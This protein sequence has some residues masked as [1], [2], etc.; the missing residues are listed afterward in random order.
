MSRSAATVT[1]F[2][3]LS[4]SSTLSAEKPLFPK[5]ISLEGHEFE[6]LGEYRYVYR[7]FFPLYEVA[8][9]TEARACAE[10]VLTA[11][12][13]FRLQFRYLREIEKSIILK[14]AGRML[15]KNLSGKEQKAIA[16]RVATINRAYTSVGK[17]DRS[18]LTFIPEEG[19]TLRING[20]TK[21]TVAGNDFARLYLQIWLGPEPISR[22][23]RDHLLGDI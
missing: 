3:L 15:E 21:V 11:K 6:R 1:T 18:S 8:L 19:T 13:P 4:L 7:I 20:E 12:A 22:S 5:Q 16:D 14:S 10:D 17:G 2:L 23:L 9:Y